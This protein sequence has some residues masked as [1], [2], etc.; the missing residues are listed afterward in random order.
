MSGTRIAAILCSG[1][2]VLGGFGGTAMGVTNYVAGFDGGSNDGF[3]GNAFF[4]ATGG[5]PGGVA[6]TPEL[7]E[8]P[9]LRTGGEGEPAN[10]AFLG[11]YSPYT[12]VTFGVDVK[13]VSM[14]DF[15]GNPD[16]RPFGIALINRNIQGNS[17]PAGVYFQLGNLNIF[18]NPDWTSYSVTIA[19]PTSLTLPAGWLGFGHENLQTFEPQL[20]P[21]TTFADIL[22]GVTEFQ[23][24]GAVPGFFFGPMFPDYYMDNISVS[25]PAP[26]AAVPVL[27]ALL[28]V[29]GRRRR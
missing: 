17:G 14:L 29:R 21:G 20:P 4:E 10:P 12:N 25:I 7:I 19:D 8:F 23:I 9:S 15:A 18:E 1:G 11:D 2:I 27:S 16:S 26:G 6:H 13:T 22:A 3:M 24:S 28:L 5:N